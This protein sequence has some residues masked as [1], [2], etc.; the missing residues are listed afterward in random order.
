MLP[1]CGAGIY[2]WCIGL[3]LALQAARQL[4][5]N[6][7]LAAQSARNANCAP[8]PHDVA[9]AALPCCC[10]TGFVCSL[11]S[12]ADLPAGHSACPVGSVSSFEWAVVQLWAFCIMAG[13]Q[14]FAQ[15]VLCPRQHNAVAGFGDTGDR[16]A[17]LLE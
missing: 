9:G 16:G 8:A 4:V 1:G 5:E 7:K 13:R 17:L 2:S 14:C 3:R 6:C 12:D 10:G 11:F 15:P